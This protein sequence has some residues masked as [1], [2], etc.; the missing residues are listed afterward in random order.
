ML[1]SPSHSQIPHNSR[2]PPLHGHDGLLPDGGAAARTPTTVD[3]EVR[4]GGE[5]AGAVFGAEEEVTLA[6]SRDD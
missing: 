4:P 5:E 2:A 6:Q 3:A 1:T